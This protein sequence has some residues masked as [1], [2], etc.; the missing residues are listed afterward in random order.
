M[1]SEGWVGQP[2]DR[3]ICMNTK[4]NQTTVVR[5]TCTGFL[6]N[7][8]HIISLLIKFNGCG[9]SIHQNGCGLFEDV[10]KESGHV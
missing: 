1:N 4:I 5:F 10:L 3:Q 9:L 2:A 6:K 8:V 7:S